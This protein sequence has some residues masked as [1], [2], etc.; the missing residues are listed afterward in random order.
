MYVC[1]VH[2]FLVPMEP[3]E[4]IGA[5]GTRIIDGRKQPCGW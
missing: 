1:V 5:P 4:G 2:V 3:E